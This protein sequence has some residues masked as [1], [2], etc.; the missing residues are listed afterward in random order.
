MSFEEII[1]GIIFLGAV[2]YLSLTL[3]S[4]F[5]NK[6][7]HGGCDKCASPSNQTEKHE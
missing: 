4:G 6:K 1:A 3:F 5:F 7:N 2:V